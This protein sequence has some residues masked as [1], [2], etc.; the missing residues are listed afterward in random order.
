SE[1]AGAATY[2]VDASTGDDAYNGT[3]PTL[4][5]K[6]LERVNREVFQPGDRILFKAGTRYTGQLR[7]QG[8]GAIQDGRTNVIAIGKYGEGDRPRIDGEGLYLD[9]LLLR[10]VEFWEVRDLE[11]TNLGTNRVPWRTGVRIQSDGFGKMRHIRLSNLFVHDVN[12]DLRKSHEGCGIYFESRGA[13]QSHF[14]GLI[15]E[16]CHVVRTDRNGIC[17]RTSGRARSLGVIIRSNLLEDIGGDGIK[18]WGSNGALVEYNVLRGGRMR[19]EDYAAGIWPFASDD[20]VIQFN[21]VSGMKGT[22]DGQ[23]FD[24]DYQSRRTIIQ[25]NYSHDNEGGFILI[26]APG[27]SYNEDTIIRYNISQND[28]LNSARVFHFGG[29]ARNTQVYN[30]TIY[31]GPGQDLPLILCTEWDRGNASNTRFFN[32]LFYVD[33]RVRYDWGKSTNTIFEANVFYGTHVN[34]PDDPL[35]TT[36]RPPLVHPGGAGNGFESLIAYKARPGTE[37]PLGRIVPNNG[38][39]DILGNPVPTNAPPRVGAIQ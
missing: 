16:N 6:T 5:W 37:L 27:N 15:I 39:R 25:Y 9:T 19:C 8:S 17:Q 21:E 10:N 2:Y 20:T 14:D 12:G 23:G 32:N 4:A 7:P 29:G 36:N 11:I 1:A 24:S 30:N 3:S 31:V 18:I 26:C 34:R 28:G 22:K 33:G 38:G 35:G 13:N